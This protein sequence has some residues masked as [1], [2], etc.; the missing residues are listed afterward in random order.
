MARAAALVPALLALA[1]CAFATPAGAGTF[2]FHATADTY[3]DSGS[4]K[5]A[6]GTSNRVWSNGGIPVNQTL[7]R[8]KVT[9][10]TGPVTDA[11]LRFYVTDK[12]GDGPAVYKTT[13]EWSEEDDE[14]EQPPE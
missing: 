4:P 5:K 3:V 11:V 8:F 1:L 13:N 7:V 2:E 14:L 12:T 9:G 6:Y 10:L